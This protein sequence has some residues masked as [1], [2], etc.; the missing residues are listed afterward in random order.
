MS[1]IEEG[2]FTFILLKALDLCQNTFA[3]ENGIQLQLLE[4]SH[5]LDNLLPEWEDEELLHV[6]GFRVFMDL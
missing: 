6:V 5:S 2:I 4:Q 1:D 3:D